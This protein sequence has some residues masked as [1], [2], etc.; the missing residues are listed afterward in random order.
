L[1][2]NANYFENLLSIRSTRTCKISSK[3]QS[4]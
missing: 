4:L 1:P 3:R 2:R